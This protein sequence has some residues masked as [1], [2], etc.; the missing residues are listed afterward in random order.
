MTFEQG[1]QANGAGS[2]VDRVCEDLSSLVMQA[3]LPNGLLPPEHELTARFGVSRTVLREATKRLESLGLL[4]SRHGVGVRVVRKLHRPVSLLLNVLIPD[5]H[6][7]LRQTMEVRQL[8][9]VETARRAAEQGSAETIAELQRLLEQLE[10]AGSVDEAARLDVTFHQVLAKAAGNAL[11]ELILDSISELGAEGRKLTLSRT[12]I[13][14]AARQHRQ[15]LEA[16]ERHDPKA[17]GVAMRNHL[18]HAAEDLNAQLSDLKSSV[19]RAVAAG[20]KIAAA[21]TNPLILR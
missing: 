1:V 12:G 16:I 3:P 14:Y 17:A 20:A 11:V 6:Q 4:E 7:R 18:T 19:Q 10:R 5:P 21:K 8:I 13:L 15:V 2:L 9:E